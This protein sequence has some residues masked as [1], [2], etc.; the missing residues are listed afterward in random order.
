MSETIQVQITPKVLD[1]LIYAFEVQT[2]DEGFR[3]DEP[4]SKCEEIYTQLEKLREEGGGKTVTATFTV[5]EAFE[6]AVEIWTFSDMDWAIG[7][8]MRHARKLRDD[9][10]KHPEVNALYKKY[11]QE[12]NAPFDATMD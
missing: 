3:E 4:E 5:E 1:E 7:Q 9:L 6:V 8:F 11:L 2:F 12:V 10:R